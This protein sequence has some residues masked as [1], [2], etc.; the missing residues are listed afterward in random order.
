MTSTT[1]NAKKA[2]TCDVPPSKTRTLADF[3]AAHPILSTHQF[4]SGAVQLFNY[5][6]LGYDAQWD[7][8]HLADYAVSSI[9]S[10]PSAVL[11]PRNA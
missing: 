8:W 1:E 11:V 5:S 4:P 6:H 7:M 9:G 2:G 3:L 10:G